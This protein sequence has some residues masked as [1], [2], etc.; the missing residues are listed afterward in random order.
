MKY[1]SWVKSAHVYRR[2][3]LGAL[4]AVM[5]MGWALYAGSSAGAESPSI[6]YTVA[7]GDSLWSIA[8]THYS[9]SE[10]PRLK[11]EAIRQANDL[12]GNEIQPGMS[13]EIPSTE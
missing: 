1:L 5:V 12:K 3:R 6:S 4:L 10:D 13:L 8:V 11:I 2:R 9:A 7:P